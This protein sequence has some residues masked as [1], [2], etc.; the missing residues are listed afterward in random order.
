MNMKRNMF[1]VSAGVAL[2]V[3]LAGCNKPAQENK[4]PAVVAGPA[5][6]TAPDSVSPDAK[7]F[8]YYQAHLEEARETWRQ[9]LKIKPEEIT[10]EIRARCDIAQSAWSTQP[11]KSRSHN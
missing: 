1:A 3:L 4:A 9:C 6:Q 5:V 7:N 2:I 8:A 11:Y 10:E